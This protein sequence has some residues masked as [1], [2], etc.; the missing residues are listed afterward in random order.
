MI[1]SPSISRV[2]IVQGVQVGEHSACSTDIDMGVDLGRAQIRMAEQLLD[3]PQVRSV[4]E[5]VG[6]KRV[7][8]LVWRD[9]VGL[10][11]CTCAAGRFAFTGPARRPRGSGTERWKGR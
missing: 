11:P 3:G 5:Q 7:P 6:D 4:R 1:G 8:E 9:L 2:S 10:R